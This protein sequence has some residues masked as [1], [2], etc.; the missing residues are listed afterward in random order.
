M[1]NESYTNGMDDACELLVFN[2]KIGT[3]LDNLDILYSSEF[4]GFVPVKIIQF[5]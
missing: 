4:S 3:Y 2:E 5:T 1:E